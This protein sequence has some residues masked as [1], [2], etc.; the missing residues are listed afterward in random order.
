EK[1]AKTLL[2]LLETPSGKLKGG[3]YYKNCKASKTDTKTSYNIELAEKLEDACMKFL[4]TKP[5]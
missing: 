4:V 2:H 1:G 3:E 5:D